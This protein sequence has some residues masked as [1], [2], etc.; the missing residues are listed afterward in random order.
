MIAIMGTMIVGL[1]ACQNTQMASKEA[2][3]ATDEVIYRQ[4]K[5]IDGKNNFSQTA[6]AYSQEVIIDDNH[7]TAEINF[8]NE[9]GLEVSCPHMKFPSSGGITCNVIKVEV[10]KKYDATTIKL[11]TSQNLIILDAPTLEA[12]NMSD[13][14]TKAG[15]DTTIYLSCNR[16]ACRR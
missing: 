3:S 12:Q 15:I 5:K 6:G 13:D 9:D 16:D 10:M 1:S 14:L 2:I 7:T 4:V 11:T 8:G